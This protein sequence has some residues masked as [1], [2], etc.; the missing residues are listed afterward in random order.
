MFWV[1]KN[2][3]LS[4]QAD[5]ILK[6]ISPFIKPLSDFFFY[7]DFFF[8]FFF[9]SEHKMLKHFATLLITGKSKN[10]VR[11]QGLHNDAWTFVHR[12]PHWLKF[13]AFRYLF[14]ASLQSE[15][16]LYSFFIIILLW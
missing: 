4:L 10:T 14:V 13:G 8:F 2:I 1:E 5:E 9:Y 11:I 6:S 7:S 15:M 12:F 16:L 3:L